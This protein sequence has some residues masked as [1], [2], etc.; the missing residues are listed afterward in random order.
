MTLFQVHLSELITDIHPPK[1]TILT[2]FQQNSYRSTNHSEEHHKTHSYQTGKLHKFLISSLSVTAQTH[3][4]T[5]T[6]GRDRQD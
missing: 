2:A 4:H 1:D 5:N 3:T 6:H